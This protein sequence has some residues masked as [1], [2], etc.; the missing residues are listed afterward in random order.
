[1]IES[2]FAAYLQLSLAITPVL[3]LLWSV[4]RAGKANGTKAM[5]SRLFWCVIFVQLLLPL[6]GLVPHSISMIQPEDIQYTGEPYVQDTIYTILTAVWLVGA[7]VKILRQTGGHIR[8]MRL[9]ERE[10]AAVPE[11]QG[12]L[13]ALCRMM[14]IRRPPKLIRC[15]LADGPMLCGWC[16]TVIVLPEIYL[17]EEELQAVLRHELLHLRQGDGFWK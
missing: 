11:G 8:L 2:L 15:A 13:E 1:M 3:L 5:D 4:V 7:A 9:L 6:A 10:G 16:R 17:T 12:I 14:D